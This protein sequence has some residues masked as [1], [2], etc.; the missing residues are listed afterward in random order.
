M[1]LAEFFGC[2]FLA[3]GPPLAMFC[4]T[5][6]DS[7][8]KI[9]LLIFS[10]FL[11][12]LALLLSSII[13]FIFIPLKSYL[14]FGVVV[15]VLIQEAF[16]FIVYKLLDK[17]SAGLEEL[18]GNSLVIHNKTVLAYVSGLG[19]GI[20]SGL[21]QSVNILADAL[22]PGTMGLKSG[23]EMFFLTSATMA[24]C[25]ILL[26]TFWSI[27]F[28]DGIHHRNKAHLSFVIL[29][30]LF[31]SITTLLNSSEIYSLTIILSVINVILT[32]CF[33]FKIV[34]GT[35]EKLKRCIIC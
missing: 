3:F 21:F 31:F 29:S 25:I 2:A 24:L 12:L 34:G 18:A 28:F 26:H 35:F 6:S 14:I 27:I 16:R 19:F 11:W 4:Y 1:T 30:H 7:P 32:M 5:I 33:A 15:S 20:I 13:W 17:T 10:S 8:I 22:G 9:I 23:S